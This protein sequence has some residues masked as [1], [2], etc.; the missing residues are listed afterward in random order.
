M[1]KRAVIAVIEFAILFAA[2]FGACWALN[3]ATPR[4]SY[5]AILDVQHAEAGSF[6][7]G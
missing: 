7:S 5:G 1:A 3:N 2:T 6:V 4:L